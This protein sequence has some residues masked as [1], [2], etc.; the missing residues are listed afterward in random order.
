MSPDK[1][2]TNYPT[3]TFVFMVGCG[4]LDW[5]TNISFVKNKNIVSKVGVGVAS[6][7][8]AKPP[9]IFTTSPVM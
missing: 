3:P 4:L 9:S 6:F 8:I 7:H 2:G 1:I 5:F